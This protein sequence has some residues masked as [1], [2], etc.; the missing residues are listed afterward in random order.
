MPRRAL[1][2]YRGE[3]SD[4]TAAHPVRR[5]RPT[6]VDLR[7][8]VWLAARPVRLGRPEH[9]ARLGR[10]R[11]RR[12]RDRGHAVGAAVRLGLTAP[13]AV[14]RRFPEVVVVAIA[15]VFFVGVTLRIPELYVGNIVMFIAMYTVGAWVDDRRRALWVRVAIIVGDVRVAA[16]HDVPDG[17]RPDRRGTLAGRGVLAVRGDACSSSS[18]STRPSSAAR[19]TWATARTPRRCRARPSS[20]ARSSSSASAR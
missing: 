4:L 11:V 7:N 3:M 15:V 8:D 20:S 2:P 14:R 9:G 6:S 10:R 12:R 18:S 5:P 17:D 19:T 13:L 16:R 1:R